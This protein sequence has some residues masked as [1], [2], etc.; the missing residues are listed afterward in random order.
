MSIPLTPP[1]VS[2]TSQELRRWL[3]DFMFQV[4]S[5]FQNQEAEIDKLKKEIEALKANP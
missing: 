4:S 1:P 5:A 3:S 2:G